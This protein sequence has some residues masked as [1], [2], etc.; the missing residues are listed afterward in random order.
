MTQRPQVIG[1]VDFGRLVCN[2]DEAFSREWLVTNGIGGY[3]S[4]TIGGVRNRRYHASLVAATSGPS[5]RTLLVG[6]LPIT[7]VYRG[8]RYPLSASR[9]RD[10]SIS[11]RGHLWLQRF[12]LD[13]A[14][15]VW[16]WAIR[17]ALLERRVFMIHGENT[18]CQ[19]WS[20]VQGASPVQ[21]EI[22]L[23]VDCR[24][25]HALG[26]LDAP[27]PA[28][29]RIDRGVKLAWRAPSGPQEL[30]VQCAKCVPSPRG[31]WWRDWFLA[32][33]AARG[34]DA[35]DCLW[36][37]AMLEV[38]LAP[39]AN[40]LLTASTASQSERFPDEL[41][42][43]ETARQGELLS[44]AGFDPVGPAL[45]QLAMAADQFVVARPLRSNPSKL[46]PSIIAGYPWF[47][48]WS[49]DTM[50]SLPGVLLATGRA[51]E[52]KSLLS[53]F[54]QWLDHG[55]LP[56]RFPDSPGDPSEF[57]AVDA[58]LL[59]VIASA[60]T[61]DAS[62]DPAWLTELWPA[63]EGIIAAYTAGTRHGIGVDPQDGLVHAAEPGV[64]LTWM[65]ALVNGRVITPRMGKPIEVNAFWFEALESLARLAT[66]LGKSPQRYS[67]ASAR[68]RKSFGKFWNQ[69][70]SCCFDVIDG[71]DGHDQSVRPNQLFASALGDELLPIG[72]RRAICDCVMANLWTP[73]GLRTLAPQESAYLGTY[74]GDPTSRDE[75]YH[76]GTVWPW[77]FL[78]LIKTHY[79]VHHSARAIGDFVFP[80]VNHL[81]EGG[82]GSLN[83]VFS[84][85]PP[86]E[87]GGC[88]AQAWSVGAILEAW[89]WIR[90]RE[91]QPPRARAARLAGA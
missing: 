54:S 13:G 19:H 45:A 61:F 5:V 7:A 86:H 10:G 12:Y 71:P 42:D 47:G 75:A 51:E 3:A 35:I 68:V 56:N 44:R 62:P 65:D 67:D 83:E 59:M 30:F 49:R 24:S 48:D 50:F 39:G 76:Q 84:G 69:Q 43:A 22:D 53:A 9:W 55:M 36:N 27:S 41:L 81:R 64:Q 34:Y 17:D 87:P 90:A 88:T 91:A 78:P 82:L 72:Q 14:I 28:M 11:P 29:D 77:L 80:F 4:G 46:A 89:A 18:L 31:S 74:G 8:L 2:G 52:A 37:A 15:P 6:D 26:R 58:P 23:L 21:L 63:L 32:D 25:H 79:L 85:N 33:E 20:L 66:V 38:V 40:A 60:R 73:Q 70:R 1:L 57:N 16:R